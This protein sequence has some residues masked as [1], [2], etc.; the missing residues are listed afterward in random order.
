MRHRERER[1]KERSI[2]NTNYN[3]CIF[4]R[5]RETRNL[6]KQIDMMRA[7][8]VREE[9]KAYELEIKSK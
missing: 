3:E 1:E 9:E 7:A 8:V 6:M 5:N 4:F 2:E